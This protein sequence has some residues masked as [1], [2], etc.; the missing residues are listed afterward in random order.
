MFVSKRFRRQLKYVL[1]DIHLNRCRTNTI[2][3]I[4][5]FIRH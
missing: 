3:P 2:A 1:Y 4:P 5:D